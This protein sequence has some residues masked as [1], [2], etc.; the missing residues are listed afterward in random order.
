M[1]FM[2]FMHAKEDRPTPPEVYN[3]RLYFTVLGLSTALIVF[4]YDTSFI[5]TT[6]TQ[7][8]YKRDFGLNN[9]S[10]KDADAFTSNVTSLFSAGAFWG[11]LF[12]FVLLEMYGRRISVLIADVTFILGAVIS[13]ASAG[14]KSMMYAGRV[15]SGIGVGG[16]V[17][18]IPTYISELSPPA[19]RGRMTGFFETFYQVGSLVG[20]WI[21]YGIER[22]VDTERSLA[23]RIPM[24]VQLIPVGIVALTI[25]FLTESPTWLL[26]KGKDEDALKALSFLRSLP[27]THQY[28][29]E[30]VDFIKE[31]IAIERALTIRSGAKPTFWGSTKAAV[32]EATMK[33]MRNR[34]GLV[35]ML[36]L[37]QAWSGAVAI[38]YY[39]PTIFTS[40]GL[41][42]TTLWTGIYG[43]VK[44]GAAIIYFSFLIDITGRKWPWITSCIGCAICM[45]YIGAYIRIA[46]PSDRAT[47]TSSQIAAGKG[48]AA[49]IM[50]F[51]FMWS[52]GANG[53][54]LIIASEIFSPSVRSISGPWAG[55]NV[56]LW[57]FVVTKSLPSMF[58]A[59]GSGIY[60]WNGTILVLSAIFAFFC[61]HE[62]KGLRMDQMDQLFGSV[63]NK[64][65][66]LN[67]DA[68]DE[69]KVIAVQIEQPV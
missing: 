3:W 66:E 35:A 32:K 33:G 39:S 64:S 58:R 28:V 34:F 16:F 69:E 54:P 5:G 51:G 20:F 31:Q 6:Q 44:S 1:M 41:D 9:M 29:L 68:I 53:L 10:T 11:A 2:N 62:T 21:N 36:C 19:I 42:N 55:V 48:A 43:V 24:G 46:T 45:Y 7:P 61:I 59:M 14:R 57:S 15:L 17:A 49:A 30:D 13:T 67:A 8:S 18:V 65:V 37:F 56:W 4:G 40:I 22:N 26:K 52:F 63:A 25:P 50:I 47:E 60:L 12:M 38:N 23:W 27:A